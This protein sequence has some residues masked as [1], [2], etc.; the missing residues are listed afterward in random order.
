MIGHP[1]ATSGLRRRIGVARRPLVRWK[2]PEFAAATSA[3]RA[4]HDLERPCRIVPHMG[5]P[6]AAEGRCAAA[7]VGWQ[8]NKPLGGGPPG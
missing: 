3:F 1:A 5:L 6:T 8:P 4:F 7:L 2:K